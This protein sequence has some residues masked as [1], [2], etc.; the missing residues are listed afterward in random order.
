MHHRCRLLPRLPYTEVIER[1]E[2]NGLQ[3]IL[4]PINVKSLLTIPSCQYNCLSYFFFF[5]I[6]K[7]SSGHWTWMC[8]PGFQTCYT[9]AQWVGKGGFRWPGK[10][11]L[12]T[13]CRGT[14]ESMFSRWEV[15][16]GASRGPGHCTLSK[17]R[18]GKFSGETQ[19]F[20]GICPH[21]RYWLGSVTLPTVHRHMQRL[22]LGSWLITPS[23]TISPRMCWL[24]VDKDRLHYS[25]HW[26]MR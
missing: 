16:P 12:G 8:H 24:G 23:C 11:V 4:G 20:L 26:D 2:T 15:T 1:K 5:K 19:R 22:G 3:A 14:T 21:G 9:T 10:G 18:E 13:C 6:R 7:E 17:A 25:T